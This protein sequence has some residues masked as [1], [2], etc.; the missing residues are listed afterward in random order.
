MIKVLTSSVR[1]FQKKASTIQRNELLPILSNI[2]LDFDGETCTMTKNALEAICIGNIDLAEGDQPARLSLLIDEQVL[3]SFLSTLKT[4]D[5]SIGTEGSDVILQSGETV[6][7]LPKEMAEDFPKPPPFSND[8]ERFK[9]TP[10]HIRAM[11]IASN[12]VNPLET[13]GPFQY[14][15][16]KAGNIFAFHS[17]FFYLNTSFEGLPIAAFRVSEVAMI[18]SH[19]DNGIEM[20]DLDN[21][22][23]YLSPGFT[24]VFSKPETTSPE[25]EVVLQRLKMPGKDCGFNGNDL[26]DFCVLAN[27]VSPSPVATCSIKGEGTFAKMQLNDKNYSRTVNQ[28]SVITG[29][30]DEFHFNS[31]IY[32][33]PM[34]SIPDGMW[35]VNTKQNCFIIKNTEETEWFC[36]IGMTKQ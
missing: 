24:Y 28:L 19:L 14:V 9:L 21:Y 18:I 2:K 12:F 29:E 11:K 30:L 3:F 8:L 13:S 20:I 5:F 36:F 22:H 15:H 33:A 17:N 10:Q 4:T 34:R 1:T 25:V 35:N 27:S 32:I 26:I 31:R 6:I 16:I 7:R 23:V